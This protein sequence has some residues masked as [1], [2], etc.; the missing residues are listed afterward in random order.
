MKILA[1]KIV[2]S[3]NWDNWELPK[4]EIIEKGLEGED[5][6]F[7]TNEVLTN[8]LNWIIEEDVINEESEHY[9]TIMTMID[10]LKLLDIDKLRE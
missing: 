8:K 10:V 3:I 2:D 7:S 6:Y 1:K 4:E 9:D 5:I